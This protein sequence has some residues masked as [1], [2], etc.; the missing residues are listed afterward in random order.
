[1]QPP[2]SCPAVSPVL[3]TSPSVTSAPAIK[4]MTKKATNALMPVSKNFK[5]LTVFHDKMFAV[6]ECEQCE[7][8]DGYL[9]G[10]I[11]LA[12]LLAIALVAIAVMGIIIVYLLFKKNGKTVPE[13]QE[14]S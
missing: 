3:Q 2:A 1:M 9:A 13:S 12:I 14:M 10:V 5:K 4:S 8:C 7:D 11:A 6:V